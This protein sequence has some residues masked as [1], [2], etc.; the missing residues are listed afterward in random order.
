MGPALPIHFTEAGFPMAPTQEEWE[1]LTEQQRDEV[2]AMLP[3]EVTDAEMSP[4]EG[5]RHFQAKTGTLDKA[6]A[7]SGY[8]TTA[9]GRLVL[10]SLLANNFTVPTREVERVQDMLV[11]LLAGSTLPGGTQP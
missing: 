4:P 7:L 5:D 9:N 3:G 6:R 11:S 10:F 1:A 8:V 2:A